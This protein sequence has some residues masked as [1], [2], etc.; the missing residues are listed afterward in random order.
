MG[1]II[2]LLSTTAQKRKKKLS[3]NRKRLWRIR[4]G[5][6]A[7]L[8]SRFYL[9][10]IFIQPKNITK[11]IT[12]RTPNITIDTK[13]GSGREAYLES[14]WSNRTPAPD[15][16]TVTAI[17]DEHMGRVKYSRPGEDDIVKKLSDIQFKITQKTELNR[18]LAMSFMIT[19]RKGFTL[20]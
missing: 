18:P 8:L 12:K 14:T 4:S 2:R 17:V 3:N 6:R 11:I 20:I 10:R 1:S 9:L 13:K 19:L 7:Q 16:D 5:F 15:K